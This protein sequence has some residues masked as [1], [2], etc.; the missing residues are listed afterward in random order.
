MWRERESDRPSLG[1]GSQEDSHR[2][3]R[4]PTLPEIGSPGAVSLRGQFGSDSALYNS[5]TTTRFLPHRSGSAEQI[6]T[7]EQ[8]SSAPLLRRPCRTENRDTSLAYR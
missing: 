7:R 6:S 2:Q 8:D 1:L 4:L 3:F 5:T